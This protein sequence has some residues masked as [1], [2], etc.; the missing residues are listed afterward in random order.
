[1]YSV[2][3]YLGTLY[4]IYK[5]NIFFCKKVSTSGYCQSL[6]QAIHFDLQ[7][8]PHCFI[9]LTRAVLQYPGFAF[10]GWHSQVHGDLFQQLLI[11]EVSVINRAGCMPPSASALAWVSTSST[12]LHAEW[13]LTWEPRMFHYTLKQLHNYYIGKITQCWWGVKF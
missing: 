11:T 7:R 12:H 4:T 13:Y 9:L 3:W 6:N 10:V 5:V 8:K 1:M 2:P